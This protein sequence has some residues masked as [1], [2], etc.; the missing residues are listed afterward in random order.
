MQIKSRGLVRSSH[1]ALWLQDESKGLKQA[2]GDNSAQPGV[3]PS[4]SQADK[5][6]GAAVSGQSYLHASSA[7]G[8]VVF[9]A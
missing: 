6:Q 9:V 7:S 5:S 4:T 1:T 3:L 8:K 2:S